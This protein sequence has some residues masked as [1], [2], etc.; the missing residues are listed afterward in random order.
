MIAQRPTE[1]HI[2]QASFRYPYSP[3]KYQRL[4]RGWSQQDVV[5]ELYKLCAASGR[6]DIGLS[7]YQVSRWENGLR[8]PGPL[9]RKHLCQLYGLNA[10]Q[11]GFIETQEVQA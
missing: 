11:L 2:Q 10:A 9:Y 6:P 8:K 1:A 5:N 4:L 3:L 7:A